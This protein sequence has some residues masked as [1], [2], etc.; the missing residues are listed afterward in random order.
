MTERVMLTDKGMRALKPAPKGKRIEIWDVAVPNFGV[1]VTDSG[2]KTY[3]AMRRVSGKLVR[4]TIGTFPLMALADARERA[5]TVLQL[6]SEGK[7][8]NEKPKEAPEPPPGT[9]AIQRDCGNVHREAYRK[10]QPE[11]ERRCPHRQDVP[12][13]PIR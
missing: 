8:P 3:I 7:N 5:R 4:H 1:R 11:C 10:E 12:D 9:Q 2:T 6:M 13:P